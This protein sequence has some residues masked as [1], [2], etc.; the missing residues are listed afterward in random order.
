MAPS[1]D[2]PPSPQPLDVSH[3]LTVEGKT[4]YI[5]TPQLAE[6]M[7]PQ[8]VL[9]RVEILSAEIAADHD[10]GNFD[11]ALAKLELAKSMLQEHFVD[12]EPSGWLMA[13]EGVCQLALGRLDAA[14]AAYA[15]SAQC[16]CPPSPLLMYSGMARSTLDAQRRRSSLSAAYI[17]SPEGFDQSA[18]AE[19]RAELVAWIE[20]LERQRLDGASVRESLFA[21][22]D[23]LAENSRLATR[24]SQEAARHRQEPHLICREDE[25]ARQTYT[26]AFRELLLKWFLPPRSTGLSSFG[27]P[28]LTENVLS[29]DEQVVSDGVVDVTVVFSGRFNS[30]KTLRY[31]LV[32]CRPVLSSLELWRLSHIW[33]IY[34][35][36]EIPLD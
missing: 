23:D 13:G 19:E 25:T 1:P 11:K 29:V 6:I 24:L 26:A 10:M 21:A 12:Q 27:D 9:A 17:S 8:H 18:T 5:V 3:V 32:K 31:R 33:A 4:P 7:A 2:L 20:H 16:I 15:R 22:L 36:E 14:E 35:D 34:P 28:E 30:S